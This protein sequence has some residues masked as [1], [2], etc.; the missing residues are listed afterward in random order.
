MATPATAVGTRSVTA[1]PESVYAWTR[2]AAALVLSSI[3]GVGMSSS[4]WRAPPPPCPTP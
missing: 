2:L 4:E 3:G 1:E